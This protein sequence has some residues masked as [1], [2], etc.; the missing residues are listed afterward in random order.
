[1]FVN[2]TLHL[3]ISRIF[4][5]SDSNHPKFDE[6]YRKKTIVFTVSDEHH[7]IHYESIFTFTSSIDVVDVS[8]VLYKL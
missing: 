8:T 4:K 3:K 6:V 2:Y 7:Q 1:M 5:C